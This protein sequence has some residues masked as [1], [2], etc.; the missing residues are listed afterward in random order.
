M[1]GCL[2]PLRGQSGDESE[3][4]A[5]NRRDQMAGWPDGLVCGT[6]SVAGGLLSCMPVT[7]CM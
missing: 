1:V 3:T 4:G 5:K 2:D 7:A 6:R